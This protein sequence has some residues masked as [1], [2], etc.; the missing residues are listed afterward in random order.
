MRASSGKAPISRNPD[1]VVR[2]ILDAAQAEFMAAGYEA[3]STNR[4]AAAFGGSKA[5]LFR[6]FPTKERLLEAVIRRIASRWRGR[7]DPAAIATDEPEEWLVGFAIVVLEWIL[8]DEPLFVG[9]LGIAEG[10]KVPQLR[11]VFHELAGAPLQAVLAERLGR[12][13]AA[14]KLRCADPAGDALR[15]FD[16]VVAGVVSRALYGVDRLSLEALRAHGRAA[17]ELFL[18]GRRG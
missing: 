6:H 17:V 13:S 18:D 8:G 1:E 5:T 2:R 14:G 9:R 16:L 4:I 11:A 7:V 12:W 3:A 15:F 10:H